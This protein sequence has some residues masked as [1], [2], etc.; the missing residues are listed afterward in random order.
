MIEDRTPVLIATLVAFVLVV[1]I[2]AVYKNSES[3]RELQLKMASRNFC[4]IYVSGPG[5][6]KR[7]VWQPCKNIKETK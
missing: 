1:F 7:K 5:S 4:P 6:S 3:K 2:L